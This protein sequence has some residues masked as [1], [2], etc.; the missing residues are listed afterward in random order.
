M[1]MAVLSANHFEG[2]VASNSIGGDSRYNC[3]TQAQWNVLARDARGAG[4]GA[5]RITG[6]NCD[7]L[8]RASVAAAMAG[9]KVLAGI[10]ISGS[11][12][13]SVGQ[14]MADVR[15][16]EAAYKRFG[17]SGYVALTVG[18]EVNDS[19]GNIMSIVRQVRSHLRSNGVAIPVST[20]HTW[21]NIS[22]NPVL[23]DADFVAANAHSWY[24]GGYRSEQTGHFVF[25]VVVPNLKRVCPGKKIII[26]ESGWPSRGPPNAN[27]FASIADEHAALANLNCACRNDPSVDVY[28]F[29]YDDQRWKDGDV[30]K[31][32][33]IMGKMDLGFSAFAAA[34]LVAADCTS[35]PLCCSDVQSSVDEASQSQLADIFGV[36][37]S[38]VTG[39]A[40]VGC[41]TDFA[42]CDTIVLCCDLKD[43][44]NL[45]VANCKPAD[46]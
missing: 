27:A 33:G 9:L 20:V 39:S 7:A 35:T 18:N 5:I 6:F 25:G 4:F 46:Q 40:G 45:V 41:T 32:F 34:T 24:D 44:Y 16:F 38:T 26:T 13:S 19:P 1:P 43:E 14:V 10:Y 11:V 37:A 22:N 29:E 2:I 17:A 30:E 31:S 23:C 21:I 12:A 36:D 28:A 15:R 8:E 42:S 3:R